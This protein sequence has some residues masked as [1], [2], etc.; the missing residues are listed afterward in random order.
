[1][2]GIPFTDGLGNFLTFE[3]GTAAA[4]IVEAY[5]RHGVGVRP[6]APYG[7]DEQVRATVGTADEVDA[8]L[9][10]SRDVLTDVP[11]RR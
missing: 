11:S 2:L 7:M 3:L 1:E 8:F 5:A 4:P 6:L 10:A 9:A